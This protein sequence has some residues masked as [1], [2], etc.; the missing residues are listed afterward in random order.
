M[1]TDFQ[2]STVFFSEWLQK[3]FPRTFGEIVAILN[4]SG[5]QYE[6]LKETKDYWCRDYMPIPLGDGSFLQYKY[7]PDYLRDNHREYISNPEDVCKRA[8]IIP[9][10]KTDLIIDGGNVIRCDDA[11]IMTEK[12]LFENPGRE[13][14]PELEPLLGC[15][16]ILLPWDRNERY[17]HADGIVRYIGEGRVLMTNYW[18]YDPVIADKIYGILSDFFQVERLQYSGTHHH[19]NSW[20]YINWLQTRDI[21]IVPS[22]GEHEDDEA[23]SQ[24]ESAMPQYSGKVFQVRFNG[25]TRFGGG[26][27]CVSW[28]I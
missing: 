5:V 17:G 15:K 20:A 28:N 19:K 11:V 24:I 16:I 3:D 10:K 6:T 7:N 8:G 4:N 9:D 23:V 21:I 2:T 12:V 26:V 25:I 13:I 14:V 1:I 18:D 22:Y 27:N